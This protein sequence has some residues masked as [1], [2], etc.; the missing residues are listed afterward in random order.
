[1]RLGRLERRCL[2]MAAALVALGGCASQTVEFHRL[3]A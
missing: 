3:A 1:M 2:G